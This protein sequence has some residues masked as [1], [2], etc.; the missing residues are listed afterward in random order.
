VTGKRALVA[1]LVI[2]VA[3]AVTRGIL[4][5]GSP[6]EERTRRLDA[7]RVEDLQRVSDAVEVYYTRHQRVPMS[8]E[9]LSQEPG[10]STV[11][12]DPVTGQLYGYR[13]VAANTYELCATF[14]RQTSGA[15]SADI[16]S[17]GAGTHCFTLK[18]KERP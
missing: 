15:R 2:V 6:S 3:G 10:L 18:A 17:H 1:V 5:I 7:R 4:I 9:A 12:R 11:A 8:L 16:W 14:D 13:S